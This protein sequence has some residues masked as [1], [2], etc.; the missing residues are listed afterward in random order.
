MI[1]FFV[2]HFADVIQICLGIILIISVL[3]ALY[4][5]WK[6]RASGKPFA[7]ISR[8]T[9]VVYLIG[10]ICWGVGLADSI[11]PQFHSDLKLLGMGLLI[12]AGILSNSK[13]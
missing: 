9:L 6:A 10:G 2:S 8:A 4:A 13:T 5:I 11:G 12:I 3:Y 1:E 7:P